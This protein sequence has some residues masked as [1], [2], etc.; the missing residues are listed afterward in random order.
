VWLQGR[1]RQKREVASPGKQP[2]AV[3]GIPDDVLAELA[4]AQ[5]APPKA[6]IVT[7]PKMQAVVRRRP[8]AFD[9]A[10]PPKA[11]AAPANPVARPVQ[12]Q[13]NVPKRQ[14]DGFYV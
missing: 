8:V 9:I 10:P 12:R 13:L 4:A 7:A 14:I 11:P 2:A 3:A 6:T 5:A 1:S